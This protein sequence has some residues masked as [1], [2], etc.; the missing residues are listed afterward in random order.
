[1]KKF[2]LILIILAAVV[3]GGFYWLKQQS[4]HRSP[5]GTTK[6]GDTTLKG[7][8]SVDASGNCWLTK[9]DRSVVGLD[10]YSL[11]LTDY[12]NQSVAVTGQYSGD[13]LFVTKIES[14]AK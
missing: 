5:T 12:A 13:T 10:S 11:T 1:M 4:A 14:I 2:L 7:D 9:S 8:L 3:G 6:V